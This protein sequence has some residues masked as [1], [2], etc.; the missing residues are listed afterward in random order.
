MPHP[1]MCDV[2]T[3]IALG[4][5]FETPSTG[6]VW[7][8]ISQYV[9]LDSDITIS[10]GR[11]DEL[12]DGEPNSLSITLDNSD[13]RFTPNRPSSPYFPQWDIGTPIRVSAQPPGGSNERRF[14]G[15]VDQIPVTWEGAETY[16]TVQITATSRLAR[17]GA[18]QILSGQLEEA[19][20]ALMPLRHWPLTEGVSPFRDASGNNGGVIRSTGSGTDVL[21]STDFDPQRP[22]GLSYTG[23]GV[24]GN[25]REIRAAEG[26]AQ[27]A[28]ASFLFFAAETHQPGG[29]IANGGY[30]LHR[31][32]GCTLQSDS[33]GVY[34]LTCERANGSILSASVV[35]PLGPHLV[36][37]ER[38]LT[39]IRV[40]IYSG[41]ASV[42]ASDSG[43]SSTPVE[44]PDPVLGYI[45]PDNGSTV[46][47][48]I[49]GAAE[50]G[51]VLT[52]VERDA[53]ASVDDY[54]PASDAVAA[55]VQWSRVPST[56]VTNGILGDQL[57][58]VPDTKGRS[59]VEA[60]AELVADLGGVVFDTQDGRLR[61]AGRAQRF[62]QGVTLALSADTHRI[63]ADYEIIYDRQLLTNEA[64]IGTTGG[65]SV[66]RV[67]DDPSIAKY[68][69]HTTQR[70]TVLVESADAQALAEWL[71]S[72]Y[73]APKP[74]VA[75]VTLSISEL[76][77]VDAQLMVQLK[78]GDRLRF[79]QLPAQAP[80]SA[81]EFF[82]EGYSESIGPARHE[83]TLNLSPA[84]PWILVGLFDTTARGF[85][86][87]VFSY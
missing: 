34:Q 48:V 55:L 32:I 1:T 36:Y 69:R 29:T 43:A 67:A 5:N 41:T 16:S 9:E 65:G 64:I 24:S 2:R 28:E 23:V 13:G 45:Q 85:D 80:L 52:G 31:L 40:V 12:S 61:I 14:L 84:E 44:Y 21:Y 87:G 49:T 53:I 78:N 79:T 75:A 22:T 11:P 27:T 17:L 60:L 81:I 82:I 18:Q 6:R 72:V 33:T 71:V 74:R 70:D 25:T 7:T 63:G 59:V 20:R 83:L 35:A 76:A 62:F 77:L 56:E 26:R 54:R 38:T 10:Y 8:D 3:E 4:S 19:T 73:N 58:A 46:S 30:I 39:S 66:V 68:G 42:T 37:A 57:V 15:F 51:R 47:A 50:W 86:L